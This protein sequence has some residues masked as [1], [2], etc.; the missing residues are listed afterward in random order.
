MSRDTVISSEH[1]DAGDLGNLFDR[2]G[3]MFTHRFGRRKK[4]REQLLHLVAENPGI[5]QKELAEHLHIQPASLSELI[6]K[7]ER[8]GLVTREKN[9]NDRRSICVQLT[10]TGFQRLQEPESRDLD[11]FAAL[12]P[13]EQE[14]LGEL[15][16]KLVS[17]WE[18]RFPRLPQNSPSD[19]SGK[20]DAPCSD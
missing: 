18:L 1:F 17:D 12:S 7:L 2:C 11:P 9:E 15:L 3:H 20:E 5:T 14:Q 16:Q 4:R 6:T 10:E 13:G 19:L 8:K